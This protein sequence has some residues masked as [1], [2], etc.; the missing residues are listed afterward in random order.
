NTIHIHLP[1]LRERLEDLSVLANHFLSI[2]IE[3]YKKHLLEFKKSTL[4]QLMKHM[5]PGN[6]REL[7]HTI[8]KAVIM[9]SDDFI[10]PGDLMFQHIE[11]PKKSPATESYNIE[12]H[13]KVLIE[14]ALN[15]FEWNMSR[16]AHELGINRSTLYDKIKKYEF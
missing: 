9:T 8:E 13:E 2:F 7:Q 4:N 5:W 1:P 16:T 3:K 12:N 15:K 11:K 10:K 14:K 6:I